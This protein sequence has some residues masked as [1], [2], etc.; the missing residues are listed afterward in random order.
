MISEPELYRFVAE[1][2]EECLD[3]DVVR[4][5]ADEAGLSNFT[6]S[7]Y[8]F[9]EED[10]MACLDQLPESLPYAAESRSSPTL[11]LLEGQ[12]GTIAQVRSCAD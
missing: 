3:M 7:P 10:L 4:R 5:I 9:S 2:F 1:A 11:W 6:V 8:D 12:P